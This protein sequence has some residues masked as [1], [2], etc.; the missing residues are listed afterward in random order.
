MYIYIDIEAEWQGIH[1]THIKVMDLSD[2]LHRRTVHTWY[3]SHAI[4]YR[5]QCEWGLSVRVLVLVA[6]LK[7]P[8]TFNLL[9][10]T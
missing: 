6:L 4:F 8:T 9:R 2:P 1:Y 7:I 10:P 5:A 3:R